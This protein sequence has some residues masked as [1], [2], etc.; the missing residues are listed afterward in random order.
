M[1]CFFYSFIQEFLDIFPYGIPIRSNDHYAFHGR[2]VGKFRFAN[3]LQIPFRKIL[4]LRCYLFDKS[5]FFFHNFSPYIN[6][7]YSKFSPFLCQIQYVKRKNIRSREVTNMI[8]FYHPR[9]HPQRW[10]VAQKTFFTFWRA[11]DLLKK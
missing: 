3:H 2:I 11:M 6:S 1:A 4:T 9:F 8:S 10:G 5:I 7:G